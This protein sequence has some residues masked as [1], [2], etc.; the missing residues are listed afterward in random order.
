[1]RASTSRSLLL[2]LGAVLFIGACS[3][4]ITEP[5]I[6]AACS[7]GTLTAGVPVE[8]S[9]TAGSCRFTS[10]FWSDNTVPYDGY[11]VD[12][13]RGRAYM[14]RL[15]EVPDAANDGLNDVD[16]VLVLYGKDASGHS[17]PLAASDDEGNTGANS[18]DSEF[19]FVAPR[20]GPFT[21]IASSYEWNEFGGYR[22]TMQECPVLGT[23]GK[24]G[25]YTFQ[26]GS[27]P[28]VRHDAPGGRT[29]TYS[30]LSIPADSFETV[31]VGIDHS[32]TDAVY[33]MFGPGFDTYANLYNETS[34]D[35]YN[36]N[37]GSAEITLGEIGGQVTVGV[38]A[39]DFDEPGTITVNLDRQFFAPPPLSPARDGRLTLR[40]TFHTKQAK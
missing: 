6:G 11:T 3:S 2:G 17:V 33:E 19:W 23:L 9:L 35:S 32:T 14:F 12:L 38:G 31:T 1:M 21:L 26:V 13:I 15:Q 5:N 39:V 7:H 37:G 30:F 10:F 24:A 27:S 25:T 4:D 18:E 29:T 16:P 20:S 8:G 34:S 36:G 28:C 22:L 40:S